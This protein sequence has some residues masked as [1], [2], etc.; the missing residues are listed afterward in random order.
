M[1][2]VHGELKAS[3]CAAEDFISNMPDNVITKIMNLLPLRD[4]VSTSILSRIWRF[5]WTLITKLVFDDDLYWHLRGWGGK[6]SYDGKD[7]S[8]LINQLKGPITKFDLDIPDYILFEDEDV[9]HWLSVLSR[10]GIKKLNITSLFAAPLELPTQLFSCLELENLLLNNCYFNLPPSFCGF[11]K[12][13]KLDLSYPRFNERDTFGELIARCPFLEV[14]RIDDTEIIEHMEVAEIAKHGNLM[15]LELTL[16]AL[17]TSSSIFQLTDLPKLKRL[18][19]EFRDWELMGEAGVSKKVLTAFLSLKR[20]DLSRVDFSNDFMVSLVSEIINSSPNLLNLNIW[21]AYGDN[22]P[23]CAFPDYNTMG[24]LQ[25][26]SVWFSTF[27]VSVNELRYIKSLLACSPLLVN[28]VFHI[29]SSRV[30]GGE[31]EKLMFATKLSKLPRA[32][33]M[34]EVDVIWD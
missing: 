34:A 31:K 12:L 5:K 28:F 26:R 18:E 15:R 17:E 20:L 10:K 19:L 14:L 29:R 25:L 24:M 4:A 7:L 32:S 3:K 2:P 1:E 27:N 9:D 23:P 16:C 13:W 11:P 8:R 33:P 21:P 22:A 30:L 6:P